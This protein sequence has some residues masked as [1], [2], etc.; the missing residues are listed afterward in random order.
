[1]PRR[2][3]NPQTDPVS[4]RRYVHHL[5]KTALTSLDPWIRNQAKSDLT[6]LNIHGGFNADGFTGY[7]YENQMWI[8]HD[9]SGDG[10]T[11]SHVTTW[12]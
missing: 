7:D 10:A 5:I 8:T 3:T 1:M 2:P 9:R 4:Y 12:S 6:Q 11:F